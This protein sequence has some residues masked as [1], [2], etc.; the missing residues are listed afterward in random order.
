[1]SADPAADLGG[2]APATVV[3]PAVLVAAA[4]CVGFGLGMAQQQQT[5]HGA[6]SIRF[7]SAD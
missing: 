3:E 2:V 7:K 1:V 5:A 6:I 4:G